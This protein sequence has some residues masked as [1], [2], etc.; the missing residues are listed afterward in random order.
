[1]KLE[2]IKL[3]LDE[4]YTDENT[5]F[6]EKNLF[7]EFIVEY[8]SIGREI[9]FHPNTREKING[10]V[11]FQTELG[12]TMFE[13]EKGY[14]SGTFLTFSNLENYFLS[15]KT[16]YN[17]GIK[18][19]ESID[20]H[21]NEKT[22]NLDICFRKIYKNGILEKEEYYIDT[23]I[24]IGSTCSEN[25]L[26]S[27]FF[28]KNG[29]KINIRYYDHKTSKIK[30][31]RKEKFEILKLE[32]VDEKYRFGAFVGKI[33]FYLND[34][35]EIVSFY[36]GVVNGVADICFKNKIVN[37]KIYSN[38]LEIDTIPKYNYETIKNLLYE[39]Q[40]N[41]YI[42]GISKEEFLFFK[43]LAKIKSN[44]NHLLLKLTH[45]EHSTV[46][47]ENLN[48]YLEKIKKEFLEYITIFPLR[49]YD[50]QIVEDNMRDLELINILKPESFEDFVI[51]Y[52]KRDLE[53]SI[54]SI[55]KKSLQI[56]T[57]K[58]ATELME[59]VS[60]IFIKLFYNEYSYVYRYKKIDI[61]PSVYPKFWI[62]VFLEA[63]AKNNI[64][65]NLVYI[66][67]SVLSRDSVVQ[68][69]LNIYIIIKY[70][71]NVDKTLNSILRNL[72]EI[73]NIPI[74]E[75]YSGL[76]D[77]SDLLLI[78]KKVYKFSKLGTLKEFLILLDS[79]I[80]KKFDRKLFEGDLQSLN[81][82]YK[83]MEMIL[84]ELQSHEY[85][86]NKFDKA[87]LQTLMI[88]LDEMKKC[89]KEREKQEKIK[90]N[91]EFE[92]KIIDLDNYIGEIN[93]EQFERNLK[94]FDREILGN[95][96]RRSTTLLQES[97]KIGYPKEKIK[98]K[99]IN[100]EKLN[101]LL[102]RK[103]KEYLIEIAETKNKILEKEEELKEKKKENRRLAKIYLIGI[104]I[105]FKFLG[106]FFGIIL[107]I[108]ISYLILSKVS[109]KIREEQKKLKNLKDEQYEAEDLLKIINILLQN[110]KNN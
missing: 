9:Y 64:Y 19:G 7:T 60:Q 14:I 52:K 44:N 71:I 8:D 6:I 16:S 24:L 79:L 98:K 63:D 54:N 104:C 82:N 35:V 65:N 55:I 72:K 77:Y 2:E 75:Y 41:N 3:H 27:E 1:M 13:V 46:F 45:L 100:L 31:E 43:T 108:G 80:N 95:I 48:N 4:F 86:F 107:I 20:Y 42:I 84:L 66:I 83:C 110:L 11:T 58:E 17:K 40:D 10:I 88:D 76:N 56:E 101:I 78:L 29:K 96:E 103:E 50:Y 32:I 61:P 93:W 97:L 12:V 33:K 87:I 99:I 94:G 90:E 37:K 85:F 38:G 53:L 73:N 30:E 39:F 59:E 62:E 70:N 47:D 89:I 34:C 15:S 92:K 91:K 28:Y 36:D 25:I 69:L 68:N 102:N 18:D 74:L 22:G 5:E 57:K 105:V 49:K 109:K 23:G 67:N 21:H 26:D 81:N 106:F 51:K